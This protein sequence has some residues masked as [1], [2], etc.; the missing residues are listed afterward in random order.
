M[1][2]QAKPIE[3]LLVEDSPSDAQL[4]L[5]AF[6][7]FRFA[8]RVSSVSDGESALAYLRREGRW[9]DAHRPDLIFLDLNLPRKDGRE[10]LADIKAD[11][12]LCAIPVVVMTTSAAETDVLRCYHLQASSYVVKPLN[13]E[14]FLETIRTLGE[15]WFQVVRCQGFTAFRSLAS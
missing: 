15:Y 5:E 12:D 11:P 9:K 10:V 2:K 7:E 13:I 8:N 1:E 6:E 14:R 4:V 3:I